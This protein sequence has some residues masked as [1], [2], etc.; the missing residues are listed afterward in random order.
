MIS[1]TTDSQI[2]RCLNGAQF[3]ATKDDLVAAAIEK[4]CDNDTVDALRA[5][6]SGTFT[7]IT[8]VIAAI[9]IV[10]IGGGDTAMLRRLA[11]QAGDAEGC[12]GTPS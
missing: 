5:I 11:T 8:Q 6:P 1:S 3:P 2:R 7:S 9:S 12:D 10:D 4:S